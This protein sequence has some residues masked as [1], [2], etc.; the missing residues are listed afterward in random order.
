[1]DPA[2][3][4]PLLVLCWCCC[5]AFEGAGAEGDRIAVSSGNYVNSSIESCSSKGARR[6]GLWK[7]AVDGAPAI[8]RS[9]P[10]GT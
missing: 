1:M 9:G 3:V 4:A 10:V 5:S 6:I 8:T 2:A 7:C